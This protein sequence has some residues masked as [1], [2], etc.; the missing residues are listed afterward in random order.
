LLH[1]SVNQSSDHL[2]MA[3]VNNRHCIAFG[4]RMMKP[5]LKMDGVPAGA[6]FAGVNVAGL[7]ADGVTAAGVSAAGVSAA[8]ISMC[9]SPADVAY[10]IA[11]ISTVIVLLATML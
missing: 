7:R 11:T 9:E 2:S 3:R 5:I 6:S 1:D 4:G 10:R 8:E